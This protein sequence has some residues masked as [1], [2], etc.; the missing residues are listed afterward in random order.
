MRIVRELFPTLT[1][2]NGPFKGL[3]Y[4]AAESYGSMLLPKLLGSYESELH[5]VLEGMFAND[6]TAIVD[7]GAA[8][9]YYAIGLGLQFPGASVYAFDTSS[10]ARRMCAEMATLNSLGSRIHIGSFCDE[11]TLRSIPLGDRALII[12]DCE[13]YENSLFNLE[14][15]EFLINHDVIIEAHDFIDIDISSNMRRAFCKTHKVHSIKSTDDI[16]KAHM[17]QYAELSR[18]TTSDKRTILGERRPGVMEWLVMTADRAPL[19]STIE[20]SPLRCNSSS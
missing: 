15:A 2:A 7:I 18:Y 5:P 3:R 12:S 8:E 19:P 4:P 13:G 10:T 9:G 11:Q 6:Y 20:Q 16:E 17:Y 1:V 14:L